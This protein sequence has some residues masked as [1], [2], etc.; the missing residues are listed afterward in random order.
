MFPAKCKFVR[1]NGAEEHPGHVLRETITTRLNFVRLGRFKPSALGSA[2]G[3]GRL[4]SFEKPIIPT[5]EAQACGTPPTLR[6]CVP[7]AYRC[8]ARHNAH[9]V[10]E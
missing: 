4:K 5:T 9:P 8:V 1:S 3:T 2:P 7:Q 6:L 10:P